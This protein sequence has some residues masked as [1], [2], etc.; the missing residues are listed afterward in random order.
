MAKTILDITCL[1]FCTFPSACFRRLVQPFWKD[2]VSNLVC[3]LVGLDTFALFWH[4]FYQLG[5]ENIIMNRILKRENLKGLSRMRKSSLPVWSLGL[6]WMVSVQLYY[7]SLKANTSQNVRFPKPKAF[8]SDTSGQSTRPARSSAVSS[9][10]Y[11]SSIISTKQLLPKS[12]V[13]W[14]W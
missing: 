8:I 12:W 3:L 7:G 10:P 4:R 5:D 13:S 1:R 9:A 6:S 2:G 11:F 14:P